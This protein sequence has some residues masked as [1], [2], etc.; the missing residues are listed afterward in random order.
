MQTIKL[1]YKCDEQYTSLIT[2]YQR[3]YSNTLHVFY[4]KLY[5]EY[6]TN[7][8]IQSAVKYICSDSILNKLFDNLNHVKLVNYW[9]KQSAIR[10][11]VQLF[12]LY[13]KQ[14]S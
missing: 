11:A 14:Y 12:Q 10:E 13:E 2:D 7:G 8:K 9:F 1:K 6:K 4:N 3:Q 5:D